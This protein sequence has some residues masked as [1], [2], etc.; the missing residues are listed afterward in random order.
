MKITTLRLSKFFIDGEKQ[1]FLAFDDEIRAN[2]YVTCFKKPEFWSQK[3]LRRNITI[4]VNFLLIRYVS[5]MEMFDSK[6]GN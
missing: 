5:V 3:R 2:M 6:M 1:E 4:L